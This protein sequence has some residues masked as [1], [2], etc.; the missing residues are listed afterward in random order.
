MV[1][2]VALCKIVPAQILLARSCV[3]PSL[4]QRQPEE[5]SLFL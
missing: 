5:I 2:W 3:L 4:G 1:L